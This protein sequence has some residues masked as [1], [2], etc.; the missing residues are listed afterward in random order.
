M[1][2]GRL[3]GLDRLRG[4]ALALMLIHH[5]VD[6]FTGDARGLIPGWEGFAVTDVAAAAFTLTLGASVPLLLASRRRRGVHRRTV[7]VTVVRRYGLLVPIGLG[8]R[9][10]LGFDTDQLGVLETLG[11]CAL[12]TAVVVSVAGHRGAA[13]LAVGSLGATAL[14][15]GHVDAGTGG[16]AVQL[17]DG[18]FPLLAYLGFALVGAAVVGALRQPGHLPWVVGAAVMLTGWTAW[19][20]AVGQPPDRYPATVAFLVPGLAGTAWL[21]ALCAPARAGSI[22]VVGT[23][24]QRAGAHTFGVFIGHYAIYYGL[25]ELGWLRSLPP[26]A[27]TVAAVVVALAIIAVAPRM[28]TPP[29]SP[30]TGWRTRPEA[31]PDPRPVRPPEEAAVD[32]REG[33]TV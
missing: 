1:P 9:W 11:I 16:F 18:T 14:L 26:A 32:L 33:V 21:Y 5:L 22:P 10:A 27:G 17:L 28:P 30:R 13:V 3:D 8:L 31:V 20:V 12:V 15:V 19:L 2:S 29:W 23:L 7:A 25:R 6:W 24:V 4:A